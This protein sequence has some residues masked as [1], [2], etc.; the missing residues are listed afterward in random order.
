MSCQIMQSYPLSPHQTLNVCQVPWN[1]NFIDVLLFMK[2]SLAVWNTWS[3]D[4]VSQCR[5]SASSG[6]NDIQWFCS[7]KVRFHIYLRE[8]SF[9]APG[10]LL[11]VS[12][13]LSGPSSFR[14]LWY[15]PSFPRATRSLI[16]PLQI[17]FLWD[18]CWRVFWIIKIK[19]NLAFTTAWVMQIK[20]ASCGW[21][22]M[23]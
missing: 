21:N 3:Y 22:W 13:L 15:M 6:C 2:Y 4:I 23:S 14:K 20:D 11:L 10:E 17:F 8:D 16:N 9:S 18:F 19:L 7:E 1:A 12:S 5:R